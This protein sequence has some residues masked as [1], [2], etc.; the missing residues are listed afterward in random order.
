MP[1]GTFLHFVSSYYFMLTSLLRVQF[2]DGVKPLWEDE[3][4]KDGGAYKIRM[5]K[6]HTAKYWE[7]L[8]LAL[9]GEQFDAE[10]G[11]VLGLV[12]S[13]KFN[14]DVV[15]IWHKTANSE[16][17]RTKLKASIEAILQLED[18]MKLDYENF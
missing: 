7:D 17:T 1:I 8:L 14:S 3:H 11:E 12:L 16:E 13:S 4:C 18:G 15:S 9:V 10:S 5:P 6:T 2:I